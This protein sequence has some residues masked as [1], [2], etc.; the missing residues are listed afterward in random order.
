MRNGARAD[1]KRPPAFF[2]RSRRNDQEARASSQPP[3]L[4]SAF[5]TGSDDTAT[6]A[7]AF[8]AFR[9][10]FLGFYL[11]TASAREFWPLLLGAIQGEGRLSGRHGYCNYVVTTVDTSER[12]A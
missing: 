6:S 12:V 4:C 1:E 2:K 9:D 5:S 3:F 11:G 7:S 10:E 8:P